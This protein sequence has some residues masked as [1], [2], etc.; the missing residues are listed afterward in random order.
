MTQFRIDLQFIECPVQKLF[1]GSA[2][3][4]LS[5]Q[6]DL[7]ARESRKFVFSITGSGFASV[8]ADADDS[9]GLNLAIPNRSPGAPQPD[10]KTVG[11][12][13]VS[14]G[15]NCWCMT[16]QL[17][18]GNASQ[19]VWPS[20]PDNH[21][22]AFAAANNQVHVVGNDSLLSIDPGNKVKPL[23]VR[24]EWQTWSTR[25][26]FSSRVCALKKSGVWRLSCH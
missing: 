26:Y 10:R 18:R 24:C 3:R 2:W 23:P 12:D 13:N 25:H 19:E 17:Q 8:R 4:G 20:L 22:K 7:S 15:N 21:V 9:L 11:L 16:H 5:A 14:R 6:V 1:T